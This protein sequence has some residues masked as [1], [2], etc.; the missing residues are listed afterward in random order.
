MKAMHVQV[1]PDTHKIIL[2]KKKATGKAMPYALR[3]LVR[4]GEE[5]EKILTKTNPNRLEGGGSKCGMK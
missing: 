5:F 3:D 4:M 1:L 2:A